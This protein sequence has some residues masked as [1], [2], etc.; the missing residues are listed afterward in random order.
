MSTAYRR[1]LFEIVTGY[2]PDKSSPTPQKMRLLHL[3]EKGE[4][5]EAAS[6]LE[7]SELML[8]LRLVR[9]SDAWYLV[10]IVQSDSHFH[11]SSES[12]R[13]AITAI[14]RAR[15][16]QK[17]TGA[18]LSDF[19]RVLLLSQTDAAKAIA[20]AD[21]ALKANPTDKGLRLLK[22]ICLL[23]EEKPDDGLKLLRELSGEGFAP[24]IYKLATELNDSE[25]EQ[26]NKEAIALY[27]RY[28]LLEP[29]DSRVIGTLASAYNNAGEPV[30]AE[31]AYRKVIEIN[32]ANSDGHLNLINFLILQ[33]RIGEVRPLLLAAEKAAD[34][35]PDIFGS[36]M[37]YLTYVEDPKFA[38]KLAASE[39][40]R[41]TTSARANHALGEIYLDNGRYARAL[42]FLS[43]AAQLDNESAS[44]HILMAVIHRKQFRWTAALNA[45]QQAIALDP[46][47]AQAH[48]QRA[49]ALARLR[50]IKEAMAALETAIKLDA[51]VAL[52]LADESD[53]KALA[54]LPAFKQL[55]PK[56]EEK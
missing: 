5:A 42:Q 52:W 45:A 49:C 23:S 37:E 33:G 29:H 2:G 44:P 27:E 24:A 30:K 48:Y 46:D 21:N 26:E 3:E 13:P 1:L 4:T 15:A 10:E 54:S 11:T 19:S 22:A 12:L 31:A 14:E 56:I 50:R 28:I 41:M 6:L 16:G 38:E 7:S 47:D 20:L 18:G 9:R 34:N 35:E 43:K 17:A 25:D 55:L 8:K 40:S 36:A 39:P 51:S 32:P 53:L